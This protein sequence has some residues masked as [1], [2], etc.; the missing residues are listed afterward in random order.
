MW[1]AFEVKDWEALPHIKG[2]VATEDDIKNGCA[3]FMVPTGSQPVDADLP[4]CAI[5]VDEETHKRTPVVIIQ[6]EQYG[7]NVALGVRYINGGN[8]VCTYEE[9]DLLQEP[10]EEFGI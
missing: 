3:V 10:N 9:V 7:N 4:M 8:G 2:R 5:Q 1:G 6:A